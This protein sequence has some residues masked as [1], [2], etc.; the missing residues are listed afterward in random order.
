[1]VV[2]GEGG[3]REGEFLGVGVAERQALCLGEAGDDTVEDGDLLDCEYPAR[4]CETLRD[5]PKG[6]SDELPCPSMVRNLLRF[7]R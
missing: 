4:S 5:P 3:E 7:A 6:R 2:F 1:M